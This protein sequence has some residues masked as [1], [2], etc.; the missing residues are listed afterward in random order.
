MA[1]FALNRFS[2]ICEWVN[3]SFFVM[4]RITVFI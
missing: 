3:K 1:L 4:Y 2:L